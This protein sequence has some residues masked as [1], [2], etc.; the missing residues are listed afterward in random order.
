MLWNQDSLDWKRPGADAIVQNSLKG[1]TSGS[2]ILMHDGGGNRDQDVEALPTIIETLQGEGYEFVTVT[3]LMKSDSSIPEDI[4]SGNAT[5]PEGCVWPTEI[6]G[7]DDDATTAATTAA[8]SG[9]GSGE[10]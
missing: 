8:A 10:D 1:I 2:I 9:D 3:E 5:M 6:K 4:A 7:D